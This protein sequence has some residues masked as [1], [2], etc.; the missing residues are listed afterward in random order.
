MR[1]PL[2]ILITLAALIE[3]AAIAGAVCPPSD[4]AL[5]DSMVDV[6][7]PAAIVTQAVLLL[8]LVILLFG[9][10]AAAVSNRS[11]KLAIGLLVVSV[12][13]SGHWSWNHVALTRR[14]E[15]LTGTKFGGF[16]GLF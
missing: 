8:L 3:L 1:I 9:G 15:M 4:R 13:A 16:Y 12:L 14:A 2:I 11:R 10:V 7:D 6:W 5:M